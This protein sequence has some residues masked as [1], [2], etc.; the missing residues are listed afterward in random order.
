MR[1]LPVAIAVCLAGFLALPT[2]SQA[3]NQSPEDLTVILDFKGPQSQNSIREM[4]QEARLILDSFGVRLGWALLGQRPHASY[5]SVAIITF[6]GSCEFNPWQPPRS[7]DPGAY[8]FTR[9]TD[10]QVL[11]FAEVNCDR[12]V[13]AV[14][15]AISGRGYAGAEQ[16]VGRALGR[17]LAH[18]L[19]HIL[20]R[21]VLHSSE[22]VTRPA[23]SPRELIEPDLPASHAP[24]G[25]VTIAETGGE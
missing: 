22:G 21:S 23:L 20:T 10:G 16:M 4:E 14:R 9:I 12:V 3:A 19:V 24:Y 18:E 17:V 25:K 15:D 2:A 8:A 5:T 1:T 13:S 11:P 7:L 6:R